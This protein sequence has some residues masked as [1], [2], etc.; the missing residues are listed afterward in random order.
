MGVG[1]VI[2]LCCENKKNVL[3]RLSRAEGHLAR[4]RKMIEG[5]EYCIDVVTQ[6]MAVQ[7]AL[8]A[9]DEIILKNHLETCVKDAI[10]TNENVEEKI[11]EF[12]KTIKFSRK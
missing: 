8:R 12:I 1:K 10:M 11:E 7:S 3:T 2:M 4:V 6:S 9:I 5:D